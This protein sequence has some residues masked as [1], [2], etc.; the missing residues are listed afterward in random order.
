MNFLAF[1]YFLL[2][3]F[4]IDWTSLSSH[5]EQD[6]DE[7]RSC[8]A[9]SSRCC[10]RNTRRKS[11]ETIER[12]NA[13]KQQSMA[14]LRINFPRISVNAIGRAFAFCGH[15][16]GETY[17]ILSAIDGCMNANDEEERRGNIL[18]LAP[19]LDDTKRIILKKNRMMD[20]PCRPN[21]LT[22]L[23]ELDGIPEI[24]TKED[25]ARCRRCL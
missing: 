24:N 19:F 23:Q 14:L 15:A 17:R 5:Q 20:R 18:K 10:G 3:H 7:K 2:R 13:Y 6:E 8:Q 16:F 21:E 11:R 12:T 25:R 1:S 9:R 4:E 22:L